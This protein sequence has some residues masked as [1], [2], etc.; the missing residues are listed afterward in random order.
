M[1]ILWQLLCVS[2]FLTSASTALAGPVVF[3]TT[4]DL[5]LDATIVGEASNLAA[6]FHLTPRL[7]TLEDSSAANALADCQNNSVLLG[8]RLLREELW[9][10]ERGGLAVAGIMAHEFAHLY[11]CA[12]SSDLSNRDRELQADY[13]AGWYLK[14]NKSVYGL[15]VSGFARS[16]ASKGDFQFNSPQHHGTPEQ[17]VAAM[18]AGFRDNSNTVASAY[19]Q[20][21]IYLEGGDSPPVPQP[22]P[23]PQVCERRVEC[24]HPV[25]CQH[26]VLVEVAVPCVHA[27]MCQH[28]VMTQYGWQPEHQADPQHTH[29]NV[30]DRRL[31][32]QFD[33]GHPYDTVTVPCNE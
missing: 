29:D 6:V 8:L 28:P 32:H 25:A 33:P 18:K 27:V 12:A 1:K 17:R 16:V 24:I 10:L 13:L 23:Q 5:A 2:L 21:L 20:S 22:R 11:Q 30:I 26:V 31:A 3:N 9:S 4:G 14:H 7:Y 15:D 19:A